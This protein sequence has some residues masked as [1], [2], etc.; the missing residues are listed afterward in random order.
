MQ[1]HTR[2][3]RWRRRALRTTANDVCAMTSRAERHRREEPEMTLPVRRPR[4]PRGAAALYVAV[5]LV[6]CFRPGTQSTSMQRIHQLEQG[7]LP[8]TWYAGGSDC[9]GRP[10]FQVHAYNDDLYVLRQAACTNFEKPFL[11]LIFGEDRALLLDTGAGNAN[12]AAAVDDVIAQWL[13][14]RGRS[15]IDLVVAHSH[16]HGDHVAGDAQFA[17][18]PRVTLVAPD[19]ASVRS[20]FGIDRW[21]EEIVQYDLGGRMLDI[22]P[23]PGHEPSSIAVYDR[24]TALLLSGDTFYPGRLY[25]RDAEA[26]SR[27]IRRLVDFTRDRP[28]AYILGAHI[29]NTRVPFQDYPEGTVDQPDEHVLALS[30]DQLVELDDA[31]T[32]MAGKGVRK[33]MSSFTVWPVGR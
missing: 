11:Y 26:F 12:V 1:W 29:E 10:H 7:T 17:G 20:F 25:V 14:K 27:S 32:D 2:T 30:R 19:T 16:G 8:P 23:I 28:V 6:A 9:A 18:R 24:R 22:V 5:L 33:A 31:L 4:Y 13:G 15:S 21:P 3:A